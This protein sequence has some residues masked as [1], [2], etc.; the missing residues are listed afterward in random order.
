MSNSLRGSS[1][2]DISSHPPTSVSFETSFHKV[3]RLEYASDFFKMI[4]S[5]TSMNGGERPQTYD[6]VIVG[7]GSAGV[8]AAVGARQADST[9][10]ILLIESEG[11]LGGAATHRGVVSFCG[12]FTVEERPRQAI[13]AIWDDIYLRLRKLGGTERMPSRHRGIFQVCLK[14]LAHHCFVL[15]HEKGF[16]TRVLESCLGRYDDRTPD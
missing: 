16:R 14:S 5:I 2:L 6:V 10:R 12:L 8:A 1:G 9:A 7:G 3:D 11:C 13:G 15:T 4:N